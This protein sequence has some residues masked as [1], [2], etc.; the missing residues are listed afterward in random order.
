MKHEKISIKWKIFIYLLGFT[1]VLLVVLWLIQICYLDFIYKMIKTAEAEQVISETIAL[2]QSDEEDAQNQ[3]DTLAAEN[4]MAIYVTDTQGNAVYSA[5]Y[6]STTRLS[7]MPSEDFLNFYQTAKE[8]QGSAKIEFKGDKNMTRMPQ[9]EGNPGNP[10]F[11][12]NHGQD[13]M[14]SVIYVNIINDGT[15]DLVLF[16]NTQ[17]T[18][19]DATV[20]T[21]RV[22]L[23][24]I[25]VIMIMLSLVIALLISRK[26]SKSMIRIND[27][28]KEMAKGKFD[29]VFDEKDYKEIAELS[30]TLTQTAKE[31][32]KNENLRRE[33][34]ANVSHDLRTPLTMII[35]YAEVMR[36]LPGENT[37][38]NVQV[39]I[40]ESKRLTNLVNDMLDISKLQAGVMEKNATVYNLTES[41]HAVLE[42][43][44]KLKEQDGY[45]IDFC[46]QEEVFV[47]A[48]EFKIFQVIYN[49]VNNAVNYTGADKT[50]QVLQKVSD[51]KVRIEVSDSGEGIARDALP[52]VWDRYYKV[53]KTHKRSV[54]G[55]GLG[56][57]I[58]K[59]ILELHEAEYGV[60]SEIG[61][62]STFWFA[63]PVTEKKICQ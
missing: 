12:Q 52:Y 9:P 3:I 57:S 43:Y 5:E 38:E 60:E 11:M 49:L 54:M 6:I 20:H 21:L 35:A 1:A 45:V 22:E 50:V 33:L 27:T 26:I 2:L 41:I 62:G 4:N 17:L 10:Q 15:R 63:L 61:K 14:E 8:N 28:A 51:G 56:L 42:R 18:P 30:A 37:P 7:T 34:I 29:V 40:D 25:T 36:D 46:Y 32:D 24:C 48:D 23:V 47:E 19:V 44:N 39:V 13:M 16:V 55:T 31:L 59:N 53:D 58:V